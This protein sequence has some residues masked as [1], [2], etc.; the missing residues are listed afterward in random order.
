ML[1]LAHLL[2]NEAPVVRNEEYV[3]VM[4]TLSVLEMFVRNAYEHG[5]FGIS[6]AVLGGWLTYFVLQPYFPDFENQS[7]AQV[8]CQSQLCIF[9]PLGRTET[10]C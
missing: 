6:L 2:I 8:N 3:Q 7:P 1:G 4:T 10:A 9:I 5:I